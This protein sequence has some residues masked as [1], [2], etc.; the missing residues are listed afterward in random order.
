MVVIALFLLIGGALGFRFK[1]AILI[2]A[3]ILTVIAAGSIEISQRKDAWS[4]ALITLAAVIAVQI[5]YGIAACAMANH[6][7]TATRKALVRAQLGLT[8]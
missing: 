7:M 5:G 2:P 8:E 4:S 3:T 6:A 1:V